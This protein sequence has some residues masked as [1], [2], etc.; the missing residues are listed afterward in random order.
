MMSARAR[1]QRMWELVKT[2]LVALPLVVHV[3]APGGAIAVAVAQGGE[4]SAPLLRI[5]PNEMPL[6]AAAEEMREALLAAAS[7][8]DL[9]D[10]R[11]A[12]ELNEMKPDLGQGFGP[13]GERD[14][15]AYWRSISEDGTGRDVLDALRRILALPRAAVP[16]G[17]DVEN[18]I[19]YVWPYLAELP[20]RQLTEPQARDLAGLL[21]KG[22]DAAQWAEGRYR[23]WK[24]SISADG[25]WLSFTR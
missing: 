1:L 21:P 15:V 13:D 2:F 18:S 6:P 20:V 5:E 8:G 19:V 25:T 10:L 14:C 3:P 24:L 23:Y 17:P 12:F 7:S 4:T 22:E 11:F 9:E 16:L